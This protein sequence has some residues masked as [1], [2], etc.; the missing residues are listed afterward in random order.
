M[1][2]RGSGMSLEL[3]QLKVS[4]ELSFKAAIAEFKEHN[5][6]WDF[7][8]V[9]DEEKPFKG[10]VKMINGWKDGLYLPK[11][12]VRDTYM[13]AVINNKIVGRVSLRHKLTDALFKV[14]G[15]IGYGVVPSE[16]R[17]SYAKE[18]LAQSLKVAKGI[19]LDKVLLTCDKDNIASQKTIEA[20]GG[21]LDKSE[22]SGFDE[23]KYRYWIEIK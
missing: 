11:G 12:F 6:D 19:G 14:N 16:R 17:K 2:E 15:N 9:Y 8:F 22:D 10:Y 13:V 21:V 1:S 5:P 18:M 23:N 3:R 7:A 20:N 4:D